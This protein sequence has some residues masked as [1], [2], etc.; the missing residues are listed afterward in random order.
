M[1][2]TSVLT[3]QLNAHKLKQLNF[4][5]STPPMYISI[6]DHCLDKDLNCIIYKI[7]V[8]VLDGNCVRIYNSEKRFSDLR[9]FDKQI[10]QDFGDS[11]NLQ[12]FPPKKIFGNKDPKFLE[13][14][15]GQLQTYLSGLVNVAGLC[16]S[17]LFK[18]TFNLVSN[19]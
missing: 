10:K 4:S 3:S 8:G 12:P 17:L 2:T 18:N 13:K 16:E 9:E 5:V 15:R 1:T 7:E 14:R 11:V 6:E 19:T